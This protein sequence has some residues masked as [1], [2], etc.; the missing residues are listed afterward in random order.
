MNCIKLSVRL[1]I[2]TLLFRM[3]KGTGT[4]GLAGMHD[5]E[6]SQY[7]D[8]LSIQMVRPFLSCRK[9]QLV[10]VCKEA[11]LEWVDNLTNSHAPF[12]KHYI[13]RLLENDPALC[14]GLYHM[15]STLDRT[16]TQALHGKGTLSSVTW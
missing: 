2:A 11:G 6:L 16:R 8:Y 15:H 5:I 12:S 4:N 14:Q 3:S 7:M 1:L 13:G 9:E 10:A